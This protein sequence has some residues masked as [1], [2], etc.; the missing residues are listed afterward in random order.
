MQQSLIS[1]G[2]TA[3]PSKYLCVMSKLEMLNS[4]FAN[5]EKKEKDSL[6]NW[7][8]MNLYYFPKKV[9]FHFNLNK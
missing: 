2:M 5:K 4:F 1:S 8:R 6:W 3:S 7:K 9:Y